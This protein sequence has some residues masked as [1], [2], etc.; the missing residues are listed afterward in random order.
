MRKFFFTVLIISTIIIG[1]IILTN[2]FL[3]S[4]YGTVKKGKDAHIRVDS[5]T[6]SN[7]NRD[8]YNSKDLILINVWATWCEPCIAEFPDLERF[9]TISD[10]KFINISF[11]KDSSSVKKFL[12]KNMKVKNRDITIKNFYSRDSIFKVIGLTDFDYKFGPVKYTSTA[13]PYSVLIKNKKIIY[14]SKYNLD[15]EKLS[16]I[17]YLNK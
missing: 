1:L 17:I 9:D 2:I 5:F 10:L 13:L 3:L 11:D 6:E 8:F 15:I 7:F 14:S 4:K 16:R 12:F